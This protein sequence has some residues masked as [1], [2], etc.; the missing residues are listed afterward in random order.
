MFS[1]IP[2]ALVISLIFNAPALWDAFNNPQADLFGT[3]IRLVLVAVLVM[4]VLSMVNR[5]MGHYLAHPK[6]DVVP[7]SV[8]PAAAGSDVG[9]EPI[10]AAGVL[11][12]GDSDQAKPST[13]S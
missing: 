13:S 10:E 5:V 9:A 4:V 8:V 1:F 3:L 11:G 2:L 7:S 6:I 12:A